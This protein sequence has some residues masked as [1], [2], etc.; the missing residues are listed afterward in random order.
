MALYDYA[1]LKE[2][3]EGTG[4]VV[5]QVS[6]VAES[7]IELNGQVAGMTEEDLTQLQT[8]GLT[9]V[10]ALAAA[11]TAAWTLLNSVNAALGDPAEPDPV[12]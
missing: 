3:C 8:M 10:P 1:H 12:P 9:I 5:A 4:R 6:Q 2:A 7:C 11:T